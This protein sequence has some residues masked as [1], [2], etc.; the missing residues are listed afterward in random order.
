MTAEVLPIGEAQR[1]DCDYRINTRGHGCGSAQG[2]F[3][4]KHRKVGTFH[5]GHPY[6][7]I[8]ER[9]Y[10]ELLSNIL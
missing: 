9:L 8:T 6:H 1:I 5:R 4:S 3:Y 2:H 7:P 10:N